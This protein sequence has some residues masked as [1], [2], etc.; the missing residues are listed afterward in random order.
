MLDSSVGLARCNVWV[1]KVIL[2]EP[3][4][5]LPFFLSLTESLFER[6]DSKVGQG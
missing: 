5:S 2:R 6:G 4:E 3:K 1:E